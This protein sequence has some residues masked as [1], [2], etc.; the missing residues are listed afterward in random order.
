MEVNTVE[1]GEGPSER[2]QSTQ[3]SLS[4][5][6]ETPAQAANVNKTSAHETSPAI[7]KSPGAQIRGNKGKGPA[8]RE[9]V[10][11]IENT[12]NV[13]V[14]GNLENASHG[15]AKNAPV[16]AT[17]EPRTALEKDNSAQLYPLSSAIAMESQLPTPVLQTE[18]ETSSKLCNYLRTIDDLPSLSK[19]STQQSTRFTT[20]ES[21]PIM[22]PHII[23]NPGSLQ[24]DE[25]IEFTIPE[26]TAKSDSLLTEG[27]G[28]PC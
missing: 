15:I 3:N 10:A 14:A 25:C 20:T 21:F 23:R 2:T 17:T 7:H 5:F 27:T 6:P 22:P 8:E 24:S 11:P 9:N 26:F 12:R 19:Q 18:E 13:A 28:M 16:V 4:S 1:K